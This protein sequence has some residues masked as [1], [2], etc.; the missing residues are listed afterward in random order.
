[1]GAGS[2]S[3]NEDP[4]GN[5]P[6]DLLSATP[7]GDLFLFAAVC[8]VGALIVAAFS[9]H[10]VITIGVA[11]AVVVGFVW[12]AGHKANRPWRPSDYLTFGLFTVARL[13]A[14]V[15]LVLAF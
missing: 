11:L 13:V 2:D 6:F 12:W 3:P 5:R 14:V 1:M 15:L 9:L 8:A 7:L 10:P 4:E